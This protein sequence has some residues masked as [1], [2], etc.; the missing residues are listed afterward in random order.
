ME[1][2]VQII[3][4]N[5]ILRVSAGSNLLS[6]LREA[7]YV[8]DAPC[9]GHGTCGKCRVVVNGQEQLAC[10]TVVDADMTVSLRETAAISIMADSSVQDV[11]GGSDNGYF[12]AFDIGTTTVVCYLLS[13][14]KELACASM[15][16]PQVVYG[17]DVISRIQAGIN[18]KAEHMRQLLQDGMERLIQEVCTKAGIDAKQIG[19]IA[20]VGNP[21]MQ[22][23]FMGI[24]LKNLV[25]MP[26]TP[27][28]TT[29]QS[30]PAKDYLPSCENAELL[31]V[32]DISCYVGADSV[33]CVIATKMYEATKTTLLVDIGTNGEMVLGNSQRMI[34]CSTAAGPAFEGA[35]IK[36]GMRGAPGAIDHVWLAGGEIKCHVIGDVTAKGICGSGLI[37]AVAVAL[38]TGLIN[39][40]GR[41]QVTQEIDGQ[42]FIPL[43]D[44]I[45]L[46][47]E[48]IREVQL[49]KSAIASGI[50]LMAA[51]LALDVS[52]IEEVI[53]AGAFGSFMTPRSACRI[54]LLYAILEDRITTVGNAAGTGAKELACHRD[55]FAYTPHLAEQ[56]DFIE[57]ADLS[58]F[59]R[60]FARNISFTQ[61]H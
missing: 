23:L 25:T 50:E 5:Q 60:T 55:L 14:R 47:Q 21:A 31:V 43:C 36:F 52:Q 45:Y 57:L 37:D 27:A 34:A 18:G 10:Q 39:L 4:H 15:L 59:P 42:R 2:S 16:N 35:K 3:P 28:I 61:P 40:R 41:I 30:V 24:D 11:P 51:Q 29:A 53:L 7:G 8:L 38:D 44:G 48:D 20:V 9:G 1:Y 56:I 32:P 46:T 13:D 17:A 54:G 33:A 12:L 58:A 22:Q 49:A 26:Y 6:V 19:R